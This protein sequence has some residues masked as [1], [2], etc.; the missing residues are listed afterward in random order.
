[1]LNS[2]AVHGGSAD[3]P[4]SQKWDKWTI[5]TPLRIYSSE[6]PEACKE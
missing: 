1:M 4:T 3:N 2:A 6:K 5:S